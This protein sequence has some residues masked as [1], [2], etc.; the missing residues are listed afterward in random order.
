MSFYLILLTAFVTLVYVSSYLAAF[1]SDIKK[2]WHMKTCKITT[3]LVCGTNALFSSK[4]KHWCSNSK[5]HM[6][7]Y[8]YLKASF[9]WKEKKSALKFFLY[10]ELNLV[11]WHKSFSSKLAK[12]L[13]QQFLLSILTELNCWHQGLI[14]ICIIWDQVKWNST[15]A[16]ESF[17]LK[18]TWVSGCLCLIKAYAME[19]IT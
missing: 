10:L 17:E 6:G 18:N 19:K 11:P 14:S 8:L 9:E 1:F 16:S 7:N 15:I 13:Y 5:I 12:S 4:K 2:W 3:F